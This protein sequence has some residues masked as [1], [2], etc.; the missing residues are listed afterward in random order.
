[1]S[2]TIQFNLQLMTLLFKTNKSHK[3]FFKKI[4]KIVSFGHL[5]YLKKVKNYKKN[6]N[7]NYNVIDVNEL[8]TTTPNNIFITKFDYESKKSKRLNFVNKKKIKEFYALNKVSIVKKL[9]T[10][11]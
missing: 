3:I 1:M 9:R 6:F 4:R 5:N 10:K 2:K 11:K 8:I 7:F